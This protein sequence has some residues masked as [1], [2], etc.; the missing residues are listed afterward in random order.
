MNTMQAIRIH[1]RGG[2]EALVYEAV[3]IPALQPG[4]ALVRVHAAGISPA[5]FTWQIWETLDGRS[6][7]PLIPSHE[8]SVA[9]ADGSSSG[10]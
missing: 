4:D 10:E 8:I 7:L 3:P 6:R 5:E 9:G 2:P 1:R